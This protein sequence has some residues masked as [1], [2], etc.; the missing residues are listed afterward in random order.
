MNP[1]LTPQHYHKSHFFELEEVHVFSKNWFFAGFAS[2]LES[3][4][5]WIAGEYAG[6]PYTIQNVGGGVLR[7]FV[8]KCSHRH[9]IIRDDSTGKGCIVCP[10]HGWRYDNN[11]IPSAIPSKPKFSNFDEKQ[12]VRLSLKPIKVETCGSLIFA[13]ADI[14]CPSLKECTG[15]LYANLYSLSNQLG[16]K[17][18]THRYKVQANWKFV[19]E[20]ALEA[21]HVGFVHH[22][23]FAKFNFQSPKFDVCE[24]CS[25]F[26]L[27]AT[28]K[29]DEEKRVEN[30]FPGRLDRH[31]GYY[32]L[33]LFPTF[34]I[35]NLFGVIYAVIETNPIDAMSSE[36][37]V[38]M[39]QCKANGVDFIREVKRSE[40]CKRSFEFSNELNMEDLTIVESQQK[41]IAH[42]TSAGILSSDELRIA[43]FHKLLLTSLV[44]K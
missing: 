17:I 43:H 25:A 36:F 19:Q 44:V 31:P 16:P 3:E 7:G 20:I 8:N 9:A 18:G 35:S 14:N 11:G 33:T 12:T 37:I 29:L 21:Y 42:A 24:K 10:Y 32:H 41:N 23:T 28:I 27:P 4:D 39:F 1:I 6:I 13:S 38:H 40:Y 5:S 15:Y 2:D 22:N 26:S 30:L 34:N